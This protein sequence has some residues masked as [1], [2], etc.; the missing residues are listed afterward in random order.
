MKKLILLIPAVL[1]FMACG[2][3]AE[4][5]KPG[6]G[7]EKIASNATDGTWVINK[8]EGM[9]ADVNKGTEYIFDGENLTLSGGGIKNKGTW[10]MKGD[11]LVFAMKTFEGEMLYLKEMKGDQMVLKV[12]NSDQVFYLDRK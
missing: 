6:G 7:E 5:G 2:G 4:Q 1:L 9:M 11:T 8:A 3:N 12:V 10:S